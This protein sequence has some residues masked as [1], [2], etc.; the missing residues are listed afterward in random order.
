[1]LSR[2][3]LTDGEE[4]FDGLSAVEAGLAI[5]MGRR[6]EIPPSAPLFLQ[7]LMGSCWNEDHLVRPTFEEIYSHL[8]TILSSL[9]AQQQ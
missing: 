9:T 4:P 5:L 6:L 2:E 7:E 8:E 3:L 1:M